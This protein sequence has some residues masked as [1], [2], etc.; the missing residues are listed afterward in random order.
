MIINKI[1]KIAS[2][3]YDEIT[4]IQQHLHQNPELSSNEVETARYI[5][6]KLIALGI[7]VYS[8]YAPNSVVAIIKGK[9]GSFEKV[10]C[11]ALRADIDA[12][13]VV[14]SESHI[15][16]SK[17]EGIMHAC[18]HD[19]H[20]ASLLGTAIILKRL[21]NEF[22]GRVVLV[23]QPSE[24]KL[25]G[26]AKTMIDNGLLRDYNPVSILGQHV[27]PGLPVGSFGFCK[28]EYMAS[29]DEIYI[30]FTGKGGHAATPEITSNTVLSLAEFISEAQINFGKLLN[31]LK[32]AILNFGKLQADGATNII[33]D[34][35]KAEGTL[36][37][38]DEEFRLAVKRML[39]KLAD[40]IASRHKCQA[41]LQIVDGYPFVL[42]DPELTGLCI[43]AA[44]L[45]IGETNVI[46]LKPRLTAEDFGYFSHEI[47]SVFYRMGIAGD[48]KGNTNL[49]NS[50]FDHSPEALKYAPAIMAWLALFVMANNR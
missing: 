9:S 42:N 36:R 37:C 3:I 14:E 40:E 23:F 20:T 26:G 22:S 48:D 13:P 32:P 25:P 18:G 15:I 6:E 19:I 10:P 50:A 2:E 46:E 4:S 33:P 5:C 27:L 21:E 49:H 31:G 17:N 43:D 24:E 34:V 30:S 47:P 16:R 45:F 44:T 38:F 35:A 39:P 41:H 11:M 12:L 28:G 8:H 29:T 7:P 1:Q